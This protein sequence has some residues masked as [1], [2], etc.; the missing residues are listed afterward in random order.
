MSD[1]E[2]I[3]LHAVAWGRDNIVKL[4]RSVVKDI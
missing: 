3:K 4:F 2:I 1:V